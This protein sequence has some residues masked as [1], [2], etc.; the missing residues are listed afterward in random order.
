MLLRRPCAPKERREITQPFALASRP[1]AWHEPPVLGGPLLLDAS[2][3]IGQAVRAHV[4]PS[5]VGFGGGPG[6]DP[7]ILEA[8]L[9]PHFSVLPGAWPLAVILTPKIVLRMLAEES[10]PVRTPSYMP[11]GTAYVW[12]TQSFDE[13]VVYAGFGLVHHS[14]GQSGPFF[15]ADGSNNHESGDFATNYFE[16]S[17]SRV[18]RSERLFGW[19]SISLEWYPGFGQSPELD[20]RYGDLRFEIA[21]KIVRRL[22]LDGSF[23]VGIGAIVGDFRPSSTK[24]WQKALERFPIWVR[25]T[26]NLPQTSVGLFARAYVGQD[27]YNV[28]FDRLIFSL[29]VGFSGDLWATPQRP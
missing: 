23:D 25:Y 5:Y 14:N 27:Y 10:I 8:S 12:F 18:T 29:L 1:R 9:V 2:S 7:L 6:L 21:S 19:A 3:E 17:L 24:G 11:Q 4:E 26:S 15:A 22:A 28:W 16:F 20:D 13:P